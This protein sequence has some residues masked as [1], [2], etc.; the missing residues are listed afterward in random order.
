VPLK[1]KRRGIEEF[2]TAL[3]D[4]HVYDLVTIRRVQALADV[5]NVSVHADRDPT[6]EEVRSMV[7]DLD[8]L[9]REL[10]TA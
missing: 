1:T 9:L 7:D 8:A 6:P 4:H 3:R 10:P 5:R 2:N